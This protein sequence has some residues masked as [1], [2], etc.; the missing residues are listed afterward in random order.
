MCAE[1][2]SG[3]LDKPRFK[4]RCTYLHSSFFRFL[5]QVPRSQR[6]VGRPF[7][8]CVAHYCPVLPEL[9]PHKMH[10]PPLQ[11]GGQIR[12]TSPICSADLSGF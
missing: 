3:L 1:L 7:Q 5:C 6:T 10:D 9:Q 8:F 2:H 11:I 12:P 4:V